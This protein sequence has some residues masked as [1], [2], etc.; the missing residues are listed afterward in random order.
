MY[1]TFN[2]NIRPLYKHNIMTRIIKEYK[3]LQ[4]YENESI[5]I[6]NKESN[7][8]WFMINLQN[9]HADNGNYTIYQAWSTF[10]QIK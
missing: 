10:L 4:K 6:M 7:Y 1:I 8:V 5:P 2:M 9:I 3:I